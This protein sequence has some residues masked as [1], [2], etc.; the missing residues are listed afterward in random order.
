MKNGGRFAAAPFFF[1]RCEKKGGEFLP[2]LLSFSEPKRAKKS[3][4]ETYEIN[5]YLYFYGNFF[6]I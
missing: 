1:V 3:S 5:N 6:I 4:K 2:P